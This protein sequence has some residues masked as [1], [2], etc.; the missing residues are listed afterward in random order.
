LIN[1]ETGFSR[2]AP[3]ANFS[4]RAAPSPINAD[5]PASA[6][7]GG[8]F[9]DRRPGSSRAQAPETSLVNALKRLEK[10]A[11]AGCSGKAL[12]RPAD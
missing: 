5:Q 7:F 6:G 9:S 3:A 2:S 4:W 8:G 12:H 1:T 11:K 10:P